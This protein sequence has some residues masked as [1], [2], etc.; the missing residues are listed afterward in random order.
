MTAV[1]WS[2]LPLEVSSARR[3]GQLGGAFEVTSF[4]PWQ[5][6]GP[7]EGPAERGSGG[8]GIRNTDWLRP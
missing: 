4:L 1:E 6:E 3:G 2:Q 7:S 8:R 5:G